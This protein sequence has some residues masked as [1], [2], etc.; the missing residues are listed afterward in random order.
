MVTQTQ[1]KQI[2]DRGRQYPVAWAD[3]VLGVALWD[4][5]RDILNSV[6][7]NPR[8]TVRSNSGSGKSFI[9]SVCAVW[10][11]FNFKPSTVITT[12]PTF[13]QVESI[14]WREIGSR[15]RLS[16]YPLGGVLH[17]TSLN[18]DDKWFA[19]GL[20]TDSP[21]RFQGFHNDNVLVIGDEASGLSEDVYAAIENP[22]AAGFTRELLIGNPTQPVGTFA[23]SFKSNLYQPFHISAFDTPNLK[24]FGI[25]LEDIR[26]DTW[27]DKIKG[28]LP[29]PSLVTPQWVADR[30]QEWGEGSY[31]FKVY[32]L[33]N[34]P[35]AGVDTLFPLPLIEAAVNRT[36]YQDGSLVVPV[37]KTGALIAGL[38]I[39]R[40]GDDETVLL[41]RRGGAV[42]D[43]QTWAHQDTVYTSGRTIRYARENTVQTIAADVVGV[44][45]GVVDNLKAEGIPVVGINVGEAAKDT[46]RYLNK[47]AE[48]Y[49]SLKKRFVK[50]NISISDNRKLIGQLADIRYHYNAKGQLI[51]ESK[52]DAKARGSR[53]PDIADALM[54]SFTPETV[55]REP[56][57]AEVQDMRPSH[58]KSINTEFAEVQSFRGR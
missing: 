42:V 3:D 34:F 25:T 5:Q 48:L 4:V 12:A 7:D 18:I 29:F 11:L 41:G 40:Y 47:R 37:D 26:Q 49:D 32:V 19:L 44:G 24:A 54:L 28:D 22:L 53:S 38:D 45:G 13:R 50:G 14:L 10:F 33:G 43:I 8:T 39:S 17:N 31:L 52:E 2:V 9:A 27:R 58:Q 46:E 35:E 6:R 56:A 15:Y 20:S 1:A 55:A 51:I 23:D 30:F 21:E 16:K 36:S 57:N